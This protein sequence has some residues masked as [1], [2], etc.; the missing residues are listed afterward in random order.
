M[1]NK[2]AILVAD[3]KSIHEISLNNVYDYHKPHFVDFGRILGN[4]LASAEGEDHKRQ[5][6]MM[7]PAFSHSAIK[8]I[9]CTN[10]A[11]PIISRKPISGVFPK[12]LA[13]IMIIPPKI[14]G[15]ST[16][17]KS[18]CSRKL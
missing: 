4:G 6:K 14:F 3:A 12:I 11:Y 10:Y 9:N 5:R 2:P 13:S 8:V 7:N 1:L 15:K 18:Y 17:G 16:F